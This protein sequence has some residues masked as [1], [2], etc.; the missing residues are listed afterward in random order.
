MKIGNKIFF[1]K[2]KTS[3]RKSLVSTIKK[4]IKHRSKMF[5]NE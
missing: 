2:E 3:N 5:T 1:K 4:R